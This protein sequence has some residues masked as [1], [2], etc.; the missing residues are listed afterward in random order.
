MFDAE[1]FSEVAAAL[2]ERAP[3]VTLHI[4]ATEQL[5]DVRTGDVD[6]VMPEEGI[7]LEQHLEDLRRR[8]MLEAMERSGG[9]QTRAAELLWR[10]GG[11]ESAR[12]LERAL[13]T[14]GPSFI[15]AVVPPAI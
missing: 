6:V 7:D 2:K 1:L 3:G 14:D 8:Y 9:V 11:P 12:A 10:E 15:E 4:D 13:A 5:R